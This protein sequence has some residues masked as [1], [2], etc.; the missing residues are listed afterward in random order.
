[1][2]ESSQSWGREPRVWALRTELWML[3]L[4]PHTPPSSSVMLEVSPSLIPL[5]QHWTHSAQVKHKDKW[6]VEDKEWIFLLHIFWHFALVT[7][8]IRI[9]S[10][11][12][13]SGCVIALLSLG[14][15][16]V[17]CVLCPH[18][19]NFLLLWSA[20]ISFLL[21]TAWPCQS[22]STTIKSVSSSTR[23][24]ATT[25]NRKLYFTELLLVSIVA[26]SKNFNSNEN[27]I[28]CDKIEITERWWQWVM[29]LTRLSAAQAR[30]LCLH[31]YS[32]AL[33]FNFDDDPNE[34]V[35]TWSSV[36]NPKVDNHFKEV[37]REDKI[38]EWDPVDPCDLEHFLQI[39][40]SAGTF[41]TS[42]IF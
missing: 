3:L 15:P 6:C 34:V 38:K 36:N 35:F 27:L 13:E 17:S 28:I 22:A 21:L 10:Q 8:K 18:I 11:Q 32:N 5:L 14:Q 40:L 41:S 29:A 24:F 26:K 42:N 16:P 20:L 1:M 9:V 23:I 25:S 33:T 2:V 19:F 7:V 31:Y 12:Q 4:I 30:V 37:Y 39:I